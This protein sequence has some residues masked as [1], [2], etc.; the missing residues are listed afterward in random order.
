MTAKVA[1]AALLAESVAVTVNEKLPEDKGVPPIVPLVRESP[2]G[3][4]PLMANV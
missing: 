3:S 2:A 4:E 1:V